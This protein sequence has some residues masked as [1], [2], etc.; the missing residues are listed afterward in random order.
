MLPIDTLK[1]DISF[2]RDLAQNNKSYAILKAILLMSDE[3]NL[4]TVAEGVETEQQKTL[5]KELNCLISQ[6]NLFYKP[7]PASDIEALLSKQLKISAL[8]LAE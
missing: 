3:L 4:K 7:M 2:I 6:G 5:L 8:N 1:L